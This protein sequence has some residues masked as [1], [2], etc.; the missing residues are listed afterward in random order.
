MSPEF[1]SLL[2]KEWAERRSLFRMGLVLAL[3][4]LGYCIA[5]EIEYR[6]RSLIASVYQTSVMFSSMAAVLLAM[7]TA[8]GEYTRRTLNFSASLPVSLRS[9]AWARLIGAWGCLVTPIVMRAVFVTL[10]LACGVIERAGLRSDTVRLPDRPSLTIIEAIG[11]LWTTTAIAVVATLQPSTLLS[12]IGTRCRNEGTVGCLGAI[13]VLFTLAFTAIRR[14]LDSMGWYL[15]SDWIGS[16]VPQSM[17]ISWGYGDLDGSTYTDLELAP[18]IV[19][20][21]LACLLIT[22]GLAVGFARCYGCRLDASAQSA[23]TRQRWLPRVTI[24]ALLTRFRFRWPGRFAALMWLNARQSVPFCLAGLTIAVL[25]ALMPLFEEGNRMTLAGELPSTTWFVGTLWAAIVAVGVFSSELKPGLEH[26][27]RSRP[28]SPGTWFWT[29]FA[30]G[31]MAVVGTLDVIPLLLAWSSPYEAFRHP[32]DR[33]SDLSYLACIPLI[34]AFVYAVTVAATCRL[35]RAIPAAMIALLLFFVLDS[36]LKSIP[37]HNNFS[38]LDVYNKFDPVEKAGERINLLSEGYPLVYGIVIAVILGATL[39]AR[40]T[41]IPPRTARKIVLPAIV[42]GLCLVNDSSPIHAAETPTA[43]D[44]V[45]GMKQREALVR[46]VRMRLNTRL[47][48]TDAFYT[49]NLDSLPQPTRRRRSEVAFL[50]LARDEAKSYELFE[51]LPCTAWKEFGSDG[52][53][54]SL[55]AFDGETQRV[56]TIASP[57][58]STRLLTQGERTKTRPQGIA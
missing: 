42:F 11:F 39:F 17:A 22:L 27:W 36:V 15:L 55:A 34:H 52:A 24:P 35:R 18:L 4:F 54:Q 16:V 37:G 8:T 12:L 58:S 56:F 31:L 21:L 33:I 6:T 45:A 29:K 32:E 53:V 43:A 23:K 50:N 57:R 25:I 7:S 49:L 19:G 47:H 40:R 3:V 13:V 48:R 30:V 38:T 51:R 10:S 5:Y 26:F 44:I 20:P 41:L 2:M 28:I 9:V 14:S 46:D 1:R